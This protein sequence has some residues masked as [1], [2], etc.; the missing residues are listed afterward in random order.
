MQSKMYNIEKERNNKPTDFITF[1]AL[2]GL[3][4][5]AGVNQIGFYNY[6]DLLKRIKEK[7]KKK[8]I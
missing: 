4:Y 6:D 3:L 5:I 8:N 1:K 2:L 7:N